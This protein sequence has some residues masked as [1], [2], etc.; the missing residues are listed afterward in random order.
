MVR[1]RKRFSPPQL[2]FF[3]SLSFV[4]CLELVAKLG[5]QNKRTARADTFV[6]RLRKVYVIAN[7]FKL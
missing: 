3:Y 2:S 4:K 5:F 6:N 1:K 7:K